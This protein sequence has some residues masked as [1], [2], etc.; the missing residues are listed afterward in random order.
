MKQLNRA[1]KIYVFSVFLATIPLIISC[2]LIYF[3]PTQVPMH[4]DVVG[5]IDRWGN[6]N[7]MIFIGCMFTLVAFGMSL[8]FKK[9]NIQNSLK[10]IGELGAM[11][12]SIVFI[13]LQVY[14]T[15]KIFKVTG[16]HTQHVS[17]VSFSITNIGI[18]YILLGIIFAFIPIKR[19]PHNSFKNSL[20]KRIMYVL[21]IGGLT[22]CIISSLIKNIYSLIP[23][24]VCSFLILL[25]CLCS[26][27]RIKE[28]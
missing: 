24:F 15:V 17:W 28:K 14:F 1:E 7:E 2:L 18:L 23:L 12:M 22:I 27:K 11:C 6:S 21:G 25:L 8:I 26:Y 20:D 13:F 9:I 19:L 10:L 16:L 5:N 3:M 4:Y